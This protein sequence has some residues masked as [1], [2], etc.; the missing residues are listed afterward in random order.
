MGALGTGVEDKSA[1]AIMTY[2]FR[3]WAKMIKASRKV[4]AFSKTVIHAE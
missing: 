4:K 2:P 1:I 3:E